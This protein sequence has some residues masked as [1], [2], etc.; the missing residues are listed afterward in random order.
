MSATVSLS[1]QIAWPGLLAAPV[2]E[3]VEKPNGQELGK[4]DKECKRQ[5]MQHG[6]TALRAP[7]PDTITY[8]HE[9][10]SS[11]YAT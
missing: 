7:V 2:D 10:R 5:G 1:A 11:P 6:I 9:D 3:P 4:K 8:E